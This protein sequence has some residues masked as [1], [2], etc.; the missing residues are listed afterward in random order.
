MSIIM[1]E[2]ISVVVLIYN[3]EEFL[4]KCIDSLLKQTYKNI[5]ILLVNDGS[6]D[7]SLKICNDYKKIDKRIRVYTKKNGG[8]SDARN[9]GIARA[10]GK[11]ICFIDSDD[12]IDDDYIEFL[13][14]NLIKNKCDISICNKY[15]EYDNGV[16]VIPS[17]SNNTIIMDN[18]TGFIYIKSF[19]RFAMSACDN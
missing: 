14:S 2:L 18:K 5:E 12:W 13:Y 7:N 1:K 3:V 16:Q 8:L 15:V 9:Y 4:P 10:I 19:K 6:T 17:K 11:Y